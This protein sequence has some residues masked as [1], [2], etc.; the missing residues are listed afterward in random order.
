MI[1]GRA[2]WPLLWRS[3]LAVK[4]LITGLNFIPSKRGPWKKRP[5]DLTLRHP[6]TKAVYME[7]WHLIPRNRHF[8]IYLHHYSGPDNAR[9]PHD[10]P[11]DNISIPLSGGYF[12]RKSLNDMGDWI[13][14]GL[15]PQMIARRKAETAH[16]IQWVSPGTLTLFLT[17]P[18][19]REWGFHTEKGWMHNVD[20][21]EQMGTISV[22]KEENAI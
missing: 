14:S 11:W 12:E 4:L 17:G 13:I 19:R 6:R 16:H 5:P 9:D 10:H 2:I 8:N 18:V 21:I 3:D 1:I 20:Y 15:R 7:R 22:P